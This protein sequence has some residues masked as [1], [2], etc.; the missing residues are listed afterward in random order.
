M[1]WVIKVFI[2]HGTQ[3]LRVSTNFI[4][5]LFSGMNVIVRDLSVKYRMIDRTWRGRFEKWMSTTVTELW[6]SFIK[7]LKMKIDL[8][9]QKMFI[10]V[11]TDSRETAIIGSVVNADH[12]L[13]DH[14]F[15]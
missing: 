6:Q 15:V 1:F 7:T 12:S 8:I 9:G 10:I 3:C 4:D 5:K 13:Y 14:R 11:G 2:S